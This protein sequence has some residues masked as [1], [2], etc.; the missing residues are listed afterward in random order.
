MFFGLVVNNSLVKASVQ[1]V[2]HGVVSGMLS[3]GDG[4]KFIHGFASG[5]LGSLASSGVQSLKLGPVR[6]VLIGGVV[7]GVTAELS[8]GNFF[9]GFR[10]SALT[11]AFNHVMQ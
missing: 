8:G 10:H 11:A 2:A 1:A 9:D 6:T 4:G 3:A 5:A 7:G